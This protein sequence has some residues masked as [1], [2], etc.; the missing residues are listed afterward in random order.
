MPGSRRGRMASTVCSHA[1]RPTRHTRQQTL[2]RAKRTPKALNPAR[3]R[4][5][6]TR[7][8]FEFQYTTL[9]SPHTLSTG[10]TL[11]A[12]SHHSTLN[13]LTKIQSI[14]LVVVLIVQRCRLRAQRCQPVRFVVRLAVLLKLPLLLHLVLLF[15][16]L[17][18]TLLRQLRERP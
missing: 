17:L 10:V 6:V 15:W 11:V 1:T 3:V 16:L 18:S 9:A 8:S 7:S 13:T 14:I 5:S 2:S 4:A 12:R